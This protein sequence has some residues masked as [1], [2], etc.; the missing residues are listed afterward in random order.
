MKIAGL[1]FLL[2]ATATA[3]AQTNQA[4]PVCRGHL[5]AFG[6]HWVSLMPLFQWWAAQPVA[7][8][9]IMYTSADISTNASPGEDRPLS[10][11]HRI[12]GTPVATTGSSWIVEAVIYTSPTARTNTR[13]I[14][15][16]PP[17]IEVQNYNTLK[18]Q[19]TVLDQQ[20]ATVQ[21]TYDDN[22]NAEQQAM[23][24][25]QFYARSWGKAATTGAYVY[26]QLAHQYHNAAANA[27]NQLDQLQATRQPI[28]SQL[29]TMPSSRDAYYI[30]WFAMMLGFSKQGMPIYDMGLVSSIPP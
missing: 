15:N 13:I 14:L 23:A 3:S 25:Y 4:W 18:N 29:N 2:L 12:T 16:N 22:T 1:I 30:D 6:N 8:N 10:A 26:A 7:T 20:I 5:R 11:W 27:L 9:A 21:R 28:E 17:A 24:H 19:L